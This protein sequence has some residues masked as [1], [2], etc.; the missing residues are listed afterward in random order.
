MPQIK[1]IDPVGVPCAES[2]SDFDEQP[3]AEAMNAGLDSL[4]QGVVDLLQQFLPRQ[5]HLAMQLSSPKFASPVSHQTGLTPAVGFEPGTDARQGNTGAAPQSARPPMPTFLA[6]VETLPVAFADGLSTKLPRD[7]FGIKADAAVSE[8]APDNARNAPSIEIVGRERTV[9]QAEKPLAPEPSTTRSATTMPM[10]EP[11]GKGSSYL[12]LP[13][14]RQGLEGVVTVSRQ[15]TE[16]GLPLQLS[17]NRPEITAHLTRHLEHAPQAH[18]GIET[19]QGAN[20]RDEGERHRSSREFSDESA[21]EQ[22]RERF[23]EDDQA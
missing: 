21:D 8:L 5:S 6:P 17:A 11:A 7:T 12:S 4:P 2:S 10:P 16:Q 15:S 19:P 20:H 18:W 3:F 13:F 9:V 23:D 22:P 1:N 14:N